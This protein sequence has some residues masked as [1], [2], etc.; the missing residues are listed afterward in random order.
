MN[1]FTRL[2]PVRA[3]PQPAQAARPAAVPATPPAPPPPAVPLVEPAA[4]AVDMVPP[5]RWLLDCAPLTEGPVSGAEQR[6]LAALTEAL[7]QPAIPDKLLPRAAALMPQLIALMRQTDLPSAEIAARVSKDSL[8]AAEVMRLASSTFYRGQDDVTDLQQAVT[9]IGQWGLQTVMARVL[10]KPIYQGAAGPWSARAGSRLWEHSEALAR[11]AAAV[12][13]EAGQAPFDGYLAGMLH[14]TGWIVAL[15]LID[16]C[17]AAQPMPPSAAFAA[18]L[19]DRVHR[20]FGLA[21]MRW[22]I[23]SGFT[24]FAGDARQHGPA[25]T[26]NLLAAVMR[27]AQQRCMQELSGA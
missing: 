15:N 10:L 26:G 14:D 21:A 17:G 11:H 12:A 27:Q 9:R 13:T 4:S 24:A 20:L 18:Q 25:S 5:L 23:T 8:L 19:D 7:A 16:R 1:W 6:A 2:W 22:D 3:T